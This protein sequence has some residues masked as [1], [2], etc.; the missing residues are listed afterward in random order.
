MFA[1]HG[2]HHCSGKSED[3]KNVKW[4]SNRERERKREKRNFPAVLND[5][6]S[7]CSEQ[8]W[9]PVSVSNP[10]QRLCDRAYKVFKTLNDLTPRWGNL[11]FTPE[12]DS[13]FATKPAQNSQ[14]QD[15]FENGYFLWL[16]LWMHGLFKQENIWRFLPAFYFLG[17]R[18]EEEGEILQS[19]Y[20][21]LQVLE[22]WKWPAFP[23]QSIWNENKK[24]FT[25]K[26][27]DKNDK[28]CGGKRGTSRKKFWI[29]K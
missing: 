6:L 18:V 9:R 26:Q 21:P 10:T 1:R 7:Y 17:Y 16:K 29:A 28:K 24:L 13:I 20:I 25:Q 3:P 4:N 2:K 8:F 23:C 19:H 22:L 15:Q 12:G 5:Y 14:K 27:L 11:M